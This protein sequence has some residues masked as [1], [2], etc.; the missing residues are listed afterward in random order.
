MKIH[1]YG[2]S[3]FGLEINGNNILFDPFISPNEKASKI[4][5]KEIPADFILVSHGHQDHVADVEEI[6]KNTGAKIVSN[7]EIVSWFEE[8]GLEGHPM[9]HGGHWSFDFGRVQYVNAVHS[10]VL[11]DG[12]YGG[13]PGGFVVETSQGNFYY[14]GDTALCMDM[15]LIG[16]YKQ[17]DFAFLPIGDNFTM[18]IEDG[19]RAAK[20]V[21]VKK[22][23]AMHYDTF[24]YIEI[25]HEEARKAFEEAGIELIMMEIGKSMNI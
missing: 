11:P 6:A 21:G 9:N 24:G 8:K 17:L 16:R 13:N 1:Y 7:F 20:M 25:N 15:E 18:G 22:V 12:T 3:S 19:V 10:S 5:V 23:I 14:A 2:H 4:Q